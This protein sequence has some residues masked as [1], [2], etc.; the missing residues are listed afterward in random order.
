MELCSMLSFM[1]CTGYL[2]ELKKGCILFCFS[3]LFVK[4]FHI[5]FLISEALPSEQ[6]SA[7]CGWDQ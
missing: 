4:A 3:F 7:V 2:V 1:S 6:C 5:I